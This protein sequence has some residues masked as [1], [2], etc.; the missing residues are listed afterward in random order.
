MTFKKF[1]L[2]CSMV[3]ILAA[4]PNIAAA[5][6]GY[7]LIEQSGSGMGNAF[8]GGAASAE[9]A[10]TIY[11]NPAGMSRLKGKQVA[12]A[13]HAI[14][15]SA[16]FTPGATAAG[17]LLQ[18]VG[19][20]GGDPGDWG[21]VPNGYFS[22]EIDP[23]MRF[24]VGV[25][26]PFGLQ[27]SYDPAWI[28]RF[29]AIQSKIQTVNINPALSYRASDTL[30]LGAGLNYQTIDGTLTSAVNYSAAAFSVGGAGVL[31]AIGG[32]G[33]EGVSTIKGK[34][35]AWGY[36]FGILLDATPQTRVG[37]A[38][39]ST[40][41]YTLTGTVT[42]TNRPALLAAAI[43]D[44]AVSLNVKMPDTFSASVFHRI[45]DKWDVMADATW[46]GWS[47][48]KQLKIDRASGANLITVQE[49]WKDTWRVSVGANHHYNEQ[50]TTRMGLAYDQTPVPD[51]YRTARIPDQN[52][53]WL[54][55]GGQYK[56]NKSSAIDVAYT[57]LFINDAPITDN[58][59]ATGKA[60]LSGTYSSIAT[61]ILSVQ[62]TYGF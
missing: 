51:Q 33:V 48:F 31:A 24:G 8:A 39:R 35:A 55:F 57:H 49:N 10:S 61:N 32:A 3:A 42:F 26:V 37:L 44:G 50:W 52:R 62:Y 25:N 45:D 17:A 40:I 27:T 36:N 60:N 56:P 38:Y 6:A 43:P 21:Y 15:P 16:K 19:N 46:T 9:D 28:G 22:M 58:Q 12:V 14:R 20:N 18:P 47:V 1:T 5:A 2:S 7:S 13:L 11:Y 54:S 23:A 34:D 59:A 30:T 41:D 29:Q 53:V 4:V